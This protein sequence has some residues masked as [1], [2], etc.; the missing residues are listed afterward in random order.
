MARL[1]EEAAE[2]LRA[3]TRVGGNKVQQTKAVH[4]AIAEVKRR[5]PDY[6]RREVDDAKQEQPKPCG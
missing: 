3:A 1:P 6:F 4:D 2:I 5:W